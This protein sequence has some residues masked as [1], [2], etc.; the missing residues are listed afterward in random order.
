MIR[1]FGDP[2][3]C[4]LLLQVFVDGKQPQRFSRAL[5]F[6]HRTWFER[7]GN[8]ISFVSAGVIEAPVHHDRDWNQ[9]RLALRGQ[10]QQ[11]DRARSFAG[12]VLARELRPSCDCRQEQACADDELPATA[13]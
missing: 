1:A 8:G 11:R 10:R 12:S 4:F 5:G 6:I 7:H 13:V 3:I 2:A 9:V